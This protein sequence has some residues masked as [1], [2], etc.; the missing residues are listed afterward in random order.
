MT[1]LLV[2]VRDAEEAL[3]ALAGG[4]DLIDI[5]EPTRGA[6]GA[7]D[8]QV[9]REVCRAVGSRVPVSAA[10]GELLDW[11][12][13]QDWSG[14][15]LVKTGLAGCIAAESWRSKLREL[16]NRLPCETELVAV[17]YADAARAAAP[18]PDEVL[19]VAIDL[20]LNTLLIDTFDKS[21][22]DLWDALDSETLQRLVDRAKEH[23]MRVALAGSIQLSAVPRALGLCP[24]WLAVRGAACEG[25]RESR[26][27]EARVRTLKTAILAGKRQ[28]SVCP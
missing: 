6:L 5:K 1:S 19:D 13:G 3:A 16:R 8:P 22:G 24:A 18:L 20:G 17:I 9:W 21:A 12:P 7:A 26:I 28:T 11:Q 23:E 2:S 4:A 14:L 10:L 27:A 15:R 25:A